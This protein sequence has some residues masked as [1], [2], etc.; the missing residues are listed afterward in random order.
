MVLFYISFEKQKIIFISCKV[1]S[2]CS[3][4]NSSECLQ[5]AITDMASGGSKSAIALISYSYSSY[6]FSFPTKE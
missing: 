1:L 6:G 2:I 4:T 3:Y 5:S